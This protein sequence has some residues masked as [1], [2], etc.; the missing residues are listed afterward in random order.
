MNKDRAIENFNRLE[1]DGDAQNL[2]A[3]ANARYIL[4]GVNES[5]ENFPRT[6][7][8][9]L[10]LGS[11]SLAFYYL[12]IGCT[13]YENNMQSEIIGR[14]LEKGAEFLEY[15]HSPEANRSSLSP[16]YILTCGLAYYASSQYSKAYII[17]RGIEKYDT[18]VAVLVSAFLRKRF[19]E[20]GIVLNRILI[21]S[22]TYA[23]SFEEEERENSIPIILFAR[24]VAMLMDY[25][26]SGQ[27]DSLEK[28]IDILKDLLELLSIERE[29]SFW[30][31]VR[32]FRIIAT[33]FETSSLWATINEQITDDI[34]STKK[35]YVHNLLFAAKPIIELFNAQISALPKIL[36]PE[37]AVVSL[38]TSSG[39]TQIAAIAALEIL[40]QDAAAKVLYLAPYRSL[41]Y[42]V[43]VS[44]KSLFEPL[45][46]SV[47]QLYGT[48]QFSKIDQLVLDEASILIATPEK[49]KVILRG[50]AH[51]FDAVKLV[52][53]DEGH[54]LGKQR[55]NVINE[56]FIEEIRLLLSRNSGKLVLL[57]A[58][59][60]NAGTIA[61]WLCGD[62]KACAEGKERLARQRLGLMIYRNHSVSL[63]WLGEEKSFNPG[64]I[65]PFT[66]KRKGGLTLPNDKALA[67][68]LTALKLSDNKQSLLLF[69]ARAVSVY[70]YAKALLKGLKLIDDEELFDW[71]DC[72]EWL[73]LQLVCKEYE[74]AENNQ[75]LEF[76]KHGIL[77]HKGDLNKELRLVLEKLMR[78]AKPRIIVATTT[79]GQGVNLGV[80]TAIMADIEYYDAVRK[81]QTKL[82]NSEVWNVIGRAG[83]AFQ[84]VEG[85]ILF[86][87]GSVDDRK[88][89]EVYLKNEPH[90]ALSGVLIQIKRVKDLA[91]QADVDFET[92]LGLI[93]ENKF[94]G[95][96]KRKLVTTGVRLD[97]EFLEIM[98]WLDDTLLSLDIRL[99]GDQEDFDDHLRN[100]LA[101]IQADD[102]K[103]ISQDNVFDFLKARLKSLK[104]IV[105]PEEGRRLGL[106][107]SG[108]PLAAAIKLDEV[109]EDAL[110]LCDLYLLSDMEIDD[111]LD[112]LKELEQIIVGF[113]SSPF[114]PILKSNGTPKFTAAE[115]DLIRSVWIGGKSLSLLKDIDDAVKACNNYYA[116]T[117]T[118]VMGAFAN[119][120]K[121]GDDEVR[122]SV[123]EELAISA[124]MGLPDLV[125]AKIYLS[126]LRSR[127]AA[128]EIKSTDVLS[129]TSDD[130]KI[131]ELRELLLQNTENLIDETKKP[132]THAWLSNFANEAQNYKPRRREKI[133]NLRLRKEFETDV[134]LVRSVDDQT[135]YL[136][137]PD[138]S[139]RVSLLT[140]KDSTLWSVTNRFD[141]Y[142]SKRKDIWVYRHKR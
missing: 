57:S 125:S 52:I 129:E 2:F 88:Q 56:F 53:I 46:F 122:A 47:S 30:W 68:A 86:A 65:R 92:L 54:L 116:Y 55:R 120:C 21:N 97:Q 79:L 101:Y 13:L 22:G 107:S 24:S 12:N 38:P 106:V 87:V 51:I 40:S 29:P 34:F 76:A 11:D 133:N 36:S 103:G 16:Y 108:L 126:G 141:G 83:R 31:V 140:S 73:E 72:P 32:L 90:D 19:D 67:V 61:K 66:S 44:F 138:Y 93:A 124:E 64:F 119:K 8:T 27:A 28:A 109:F 113:P 91:K 63:E 17:L 99:E 94:S 18:D 104:E 33:G 35:S 81:K 130:I 25:L 49:A 60:P 3:R 96:R 23:E 134:L 43:E 137:S 112:L 26:F 142:F 59:L 100:T 9:N 15:N 136:V 127:S 89:A 77:C 102:L 20:V 7:E 139:E 6:L 80:S 110:E 78:N 41:A 48:G 114:Q 71:Q 121:S 50:N 14:C 118:W 128:M 117:I 132:L 62:E 105:V 98:D 5:R 4:F 42:E 39:K 85:K 75:I 10:D 1:R 135:L 131:H 58:V 84:D 111:K 74:S 115:Y 95:F 70:T 82:T 69:T 37:G 45:N 123:F